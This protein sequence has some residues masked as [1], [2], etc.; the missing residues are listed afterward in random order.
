MSFAASHAPPVSIVERARI[1]SVDGMARLLG[2]KHKTDVLQVY[3]LLERPPSWG[4][5]TTLTGVFL[6]GDDWAAF[7]DQG[8]GAA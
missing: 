1:E 3:E 6:A 7:R 5:L 8:D 4:V 2:C